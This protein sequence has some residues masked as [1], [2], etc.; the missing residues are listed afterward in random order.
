MVILPL[1]DSLFLSSPEIVFADSPLGEKAFI[2]IR[3]PLFL[4]SV[5]ANKSFYLFIFF[6][7]SH[8]HG[9]PLRLLITYFL[10]YYL[11][12]PHCGDHPY[13]SCLIIIYNLSTLYTIQSDLSEK[14]CYC[15][16]HNVFP[17]ALCSV[18]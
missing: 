3:H 2:T 7:K 18:N 16:S 4:H 15:L 9:H 17:T 14:T 10:A 6:M 13:F 8:Q 11:T 1:I 12:S 5:F